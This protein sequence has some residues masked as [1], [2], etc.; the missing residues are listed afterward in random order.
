MPARASGNALVKTALPNEIA[1][2]EAGPFEYPM[3]RRDDPLR[4]R[5][6]N[7]AVVAYHGDQISL[8]FDAAVEPAFELPGAHRTRIGNL[9][10]ASHCRFVEKFDFA[11]ETIPSQV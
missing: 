6:H 11:V 1:L 8:R 3:V 10:M 9:R 2:L 4:P 7:S 5:R